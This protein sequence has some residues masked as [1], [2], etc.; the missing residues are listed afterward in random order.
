MRT[1]CRFIRWPAAVA[2]SCLLLAS[3]VVQARPAAEP[4]DLIVHNA[5]VWTVDDAHP[6]AQAVAVRGNRIVKVGDDAEVLA[7]KGARTRTLDV[8]GRLV[9]PGFIDGHTHFENAAEWF[10]EARLVDVNDEAG[11]L[12][13]LAETAARVPEGMWIT[14]YDWGSFAA[15]AARRAGDRGFVGFAPSLAAVDRV[16]S[17][18]PVLLR[19][20]DGSYFVNSLGMRLLRIDRNSLNPSNGEYQRDPATGEL[21]G[22]LFGS[23]G[24]RMAQTLPPPSRARTLIA[25]EWL[26]KDLNRQGITGIHDI[27]RVEAISQQQ[28][29]HTHVERSNSDLSIFTD[30][31]DRGRL[32]L[33]VNPILTMANWRDYASH[34]IVPQG[35]DDMIR[36]G[37]LKAFIDGFYMEEPYLDNPQNAGGLTFRVVDEASM[38]R[39]LVAADRLGFDPAVHVIGDKAHRLLLDWY[40]TAVARNPARDRRLRVIH[41]WFPNAHDIERAGRLGAVADITPYHLMR[42]KK[43]VDAKLGPAR[44]QTAFAWRTMIDNGIRLNIVSDWPGSFD[45]G[46]IAPINPMENLWYALTRQDVGGDPAGGWRPEQALTIEEAIRAYTINPAHTTHEQAIRGSITEGKL[47][48]LIVLSDNILEL[49][50]AQLLDTR[51]LYTIFDGRVAYEA[52]P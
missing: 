7:L 14:G 26:V 48:D 24:G 25:A 41:A 47:A 16:T 36:Y 51:V 49:A 18:H 43:I 31:R 27:A 15:A 40:E 1:P 22:M 21:T 3:A 6:L 42:E 13:R 8:Q 10:Y 23:A 17:R 5:R 52:V 9:L 12:E 20:H 37:G 30:L 34:G 4:V 29:Y 11:M 19:R 39:D 44:A 32:T 38:E 33:R 35:G 50:P 2:T 46:N 45:R 28:I